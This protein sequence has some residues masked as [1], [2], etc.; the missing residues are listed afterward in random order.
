[1]YWGKPISSSHP[2]KTDALTF[3]RKKDMGAKRERQKWS[4]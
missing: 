3:I 4:F 2:A 1:L